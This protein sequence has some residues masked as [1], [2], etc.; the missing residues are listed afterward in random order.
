VERHPETFHTERMLLELTDNL[1]RTIVVKTRTL[2]TWPSYG[3]WP[4]QMVL[5]NS[6]ELECEGM[7]THG[8]TFDLYSND[9]MQ[10]RAN[11]RRP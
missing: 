9:F 5:C 11:L 1:G 2:T 6:V 4:N 10:H 8:E 7:R 3:F